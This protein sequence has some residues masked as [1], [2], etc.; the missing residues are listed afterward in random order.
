[1]QSGKTFLTAVACAVATLLDI[2]VIIVNHQNAGR[3]NMMQNM[4]GVDG[5]FRGL[6]AVDNKNFNHLQIVIEDL[7]K[8]NSKAVLDG[9]SRMQNNSRGI[10][11]IANT[12]KQ[13]EEARKIAHTLPR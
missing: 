8:P 2:A 10:I 3:N 9:Q 4:E 5:F 11:N 1:M 6:R 12:N 7:C 13:L